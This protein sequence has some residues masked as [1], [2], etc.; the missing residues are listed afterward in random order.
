MLAPSPV[1]RLRLQARPG[2]AALLRER[3]RLWL[4]EIEVNEEEAFDVLL[5]VGEAFANA[6][7]HPR[8]PAVKLIEVEAESAGGALTVVVRDFG[9]WADSRQREGGY[10]FS[11]MRWLM[12][13]VDVDAD[14]DGTAITL[15]RHIAGVGSAR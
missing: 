5:A 12:D 3:L 10:G 9:T 11:L 7:E 15:R 2:S 4:D 1:L 8:A 13:S 14:L 6:V